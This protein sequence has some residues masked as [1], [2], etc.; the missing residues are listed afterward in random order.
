MKQTLLNKYMKGESTASEERKLLDLLL[1]T[2]QEQLAQDE[3]TIL[4]LLSYSEQEEDDAEDIFAVDYTDEYD[5]V[6]KP[7]RTI[8]MWHWAAAACV[9]GVLIMFLMPPKTNTEVVEDTKVVA[10]VEPPVTHTTASQQAEEAPENKYVSETV[11]TQKHSKAAS[12]A[13]TVVPR[14]TEEAEPD[15]E[16][17][18]MSEETRMELLMAYLSPEE[19]M[20]MEIDHEE[21]IRQMRIRGERMINKM[22]TE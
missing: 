11:V 8:R 14:P 13:I 10:K 12:V 7:T 22:K 1:E 2:P 9:A 16:P 19:Q 20:P 21:E 6:A 18:Q 17:V 4:E 5:K 15:E 3:R